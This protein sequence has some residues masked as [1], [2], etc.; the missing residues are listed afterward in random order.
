V[1]FDLDLTGLKILVLG[2]EKKINKNQRLRAKHFDEPEKFLE[3]EL[4]LDEEIKKLYAV[5]ASPELYGDMVKLGCVKSLLGLLTHDNTDVSLAVVGLLGELTDP[6]TAEEAAESM[7]SLVDA[8]VANQ[9]LE[10]LVQ[11]LGRLDEARSSE[12]AE[13]VHATLGVLEN[14]LD[15]RPSQIAKQLCVDT[16]VLKFLLKRLKARKFDPIKLYASEILSILLNQ[17]DTGENDAES[18]SSSG[19]TGG[20]NNAKRLGDLQGEDG[21]D[22][23]L[24]AC[25]YYR[26]RDPSCEEEEELIENL[27]N[28][29][30][31][32]CTHCADNKGRFR[33]SQ[34]FELMARCMK[35]KNHAGACALRVLDCALQQSPVNCEAFVAAGGLK[36]LFPAFMGKGVVRT[37]GGFCAPKKLPE[38]AAKGAKE[39]ASRRL[40]MLKKRQKS[41]GY[42]QE[43]KEAEAA[44]E[45]NA[46]SAVATL[47]VQL[48]VGTAVQGEA[49]QG[50]KAKGDALPRLVSKF[51]EDDLIKVDRLVELC[52]E[53][54]AKVLAHDLKAAQGVIN[55]DLGE[56]DSEDEEDMALLPGRSKVEA[57]S[58][59]RLAAGLFTLQLLSVVAATVSIQSPK[60]RVRL[61]EKLLELS[62]KGQAKATT[63]WLRDLLLGYA[64]SVH[65]GVEDQ[66]RQ[67]RA[68]MEALHEEGEVVSFGAGAGADAAELAKEK[69]RAELLARIAA[70]FPVDEEAEGGGEEEEVEEEEGKAP[71]A[72]EAAETAEEESKVGGVE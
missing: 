37:A 28:C 31:A 55:Q 52:C 27:F 23:L 15:F 25:A 43:L 72:S 2:F 35:E 64:A 47:C 59:R 14:L 13:G 65:K 44:A 61:S 26:K 10:L 56:L 67:A 53:Y 1:D 46:I 29:L 3:S 51:L 4:E 40:K 11:N 5:S 22:E 32:S 48:Q 49:G 16:G 36:V 63:K 69:Q 30:V 71:E 62:G 66:D 17:S 20:N 24:Q 45:G 21:V 70:T 19:S 34:G 33:H 57:A 39:A 38:G 58:Q 18:G 8:L 50:L 7:T 41:S 42:E 54:D 12:E 9:G 68:R 60:A 6:E